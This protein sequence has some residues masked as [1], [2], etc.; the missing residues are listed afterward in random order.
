MALFTFLVGQL[1]TN[2]NSSASVMSLIAMNKTIVTSNFKI[3]NIVFG[4]FLNFS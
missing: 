2:A 1:E 4:I 3:N